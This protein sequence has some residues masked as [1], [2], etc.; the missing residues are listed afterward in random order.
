M[1]HSL[2]PL[3]PLRAFEAVAR[4]GSL[5]A[6]AEDLSV[7]HTVVGRH[8][9]K[10]ED[11]FGLK[12]VDS[13]FS[14][15]RLTPIGKR[16]FGRITEAF[17]ALSDAT[18]DLRPADG[19]QIRIWCGP[20]LNKVWFMPRL[21]QVS[22]AVDASVVLMRATDHL[23]DFRRFEADVAIHYGREYVP[24]SNSIEL[25][26][27]RMH[28]VASPSFASEHA[29][30][31]K[32]ADLLAVPLLHEQSTEW[33]QKWFAANGVRLS[34]P[35]KGPRLGYAHVAL[36]A[37]ILGQGVALINSVMAVPEIEAGRLVDVMPTDVQFEAYYFYAAENRWNEPAIVKLR[38]WMVKTMTSETASGAG[39][40]PSAA[41]V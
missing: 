34:G 14:E 33:W 24:S 32:P 17:Q 31:T 29:G 37:A 41:A 21:Q 10:L 30:L 13:S 9:R 27:P 36:E 35:L 1:P 5:R 40:P 12:L 8:V 25:V 7:H 26:R 16:Y 6:A 3:I 18:D 23:P 39:K 22:E 2:P 4:L 38:K 19:P 15:T 28:V 20:G 11:W